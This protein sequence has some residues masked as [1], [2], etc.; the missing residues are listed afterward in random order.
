MSLRS[1]LIL[2]SFIFTSPDF[3]AFTSAA[4][5][6]FVLQQISSMGFDHRITQPG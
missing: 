3:A 1:G 2:E 5:N 6:S 4:D